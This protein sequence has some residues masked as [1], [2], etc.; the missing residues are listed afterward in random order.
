MAGKS[1][2]WLRTAFR[3]H[4]YDLLRLCVGTGQAQLPS[5]CP[6]GPA[7]LMRLTGAR[8][9]HPC[10]PPTEPLKVPPGMLPTQ[11]VQVEAVDFSNLGTPP[12]PA[13]ATKSIEKEKKPPRSA[14]PDLPETLH[15]G[16]PSQAGGPLMEGRGGVQSYT[17]KLHMKTDP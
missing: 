4:C 8:L 15:S 6:V 16:A 9:C 1:A 13:N 17:E 10:L 5:L 3:R 7:L 14:S 11:A 2:S 12:P